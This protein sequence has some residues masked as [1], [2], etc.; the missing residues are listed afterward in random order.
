M[1]IIRD[2]LTFTVESVVSS[3]SVTK[4]DNMLKEVNIN[5]Y[6]EIVTKNPF[7]IED[8]EFF[9]LTATTK[10][11]QA[12]EPSS[13]RN[14]MLYGTISGDQGLGYAVIAKANKTQ[15]IFRVGEMV[16][17]VGILEG[18]TADSAS[19]EGGIWLSI[20]DISKGGD[21]RQLP[22]KMD[23][24]SDNGT[25][26]ELVKPVSDN[27]YVVDKDMVKSAIENPKQLM[28]E[29]RLLPRYNNGKQ[30][31]FYM[32]GIKAGGIYD[33]LGLK[34]GDAL[35]KINDYDL[36]DPERALQAFSALRGAS[37]IELSVLRNSEHIT[38]DYE[39]R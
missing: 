21:K 2:Y 7:G 10:N 8:A 24:K 4:N 26:K 19:I 37:K 11:R 16:F 33:S 3:V 15:G 17:D 23:D 12:K 6:A 18:V 31:G 20:I 34:D 35:L 28:T 1:Y 13:T 36:T 14:L 5:D 9:P 27:A 29:A 30:E 22:T 25:T 38:L 32:K 39:I